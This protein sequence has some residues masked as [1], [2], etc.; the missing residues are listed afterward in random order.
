M[1]QKT[2][3]MIP[4]SWLNSDPFFADRDA[5][6]EAYQAYLLDRLAA[7]HYFVEEALHARAKLL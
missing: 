5:H 4:G 1:I 2:V 3:N 6:R 7:S